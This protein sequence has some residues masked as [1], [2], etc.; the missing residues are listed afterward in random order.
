[1]FG[2][3]LLLLAT[4]AALG[5]SVLLSIPIPN[6]PTL[7][8]TTLYMLL[9][10]LFLLTVLF[11]V[12]YY[13]TRTAY[14][15]LGMAL[16]AI[17]GA[18][19]LYFRHEW[20]GNAALI[21]WVSAIL[22]GAA[23]FVTIVNNPS[24]LPVYY[25]NRVAYV[26]KFK[27]DN[28]NHLHEELSRQSDFLPGTFR[29]FT[30]TEEKTGDRVKKVKQELVECHDVKDV[31]DIHAEL[32]PDSPDA[33]MAD[34][35][36]IKQSMQR[37][38]DDAWFHIFDV[39]VLDDVLMGNWKDRQEMNEMLLQCAMS[40][41][42]LDIT[43]RGR[44][45]LEIDVVAAASLLI[46]LKAL[47]GRDVLFQQKALH[48]VRERMA[49][50]WTVEQLRDYEI[51]VF[52]TSEWLGCSEVEKVWRDKFNEWVKDKPEILLAFRKTKGKRFR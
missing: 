19:L 11:A 14:L 2:L 46:S 38:I 34:E 7:P 52:E 24:T 21:G 39:R 6:L 9:L 42:N 13:R 20:S 25:L 40:L 8:N 16:G 37:T 49:P 50:E 47:M 33:F 17:A 3:K 4:G 41:Y 35:E 36:R 32:L 51:A 43:K 18:I 22:L 12:Y 5:W 44:S 28:C 1:M 26:D 30:Y 29:L 15:G 27:V 10:S 23:T 31:K 48:Y 45:I